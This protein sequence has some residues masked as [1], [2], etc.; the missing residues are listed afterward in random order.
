MKRKVLQDERITAEHQKLNSQ[1]FYIIFA[2]LMVSLVVKVFI[3]HWDMKYWLDVFLI[4]IAA[5][6]YITV[7]A[8]RRGLYLLPGQ[9]GEKP[10]FKKANLWSGAIGAIVWTILMISYD[11]LESGTTD[12]IKNVASA[13]VGGVIFF[14]GM[15]WIQRALV[16][17]STQN[18]DKPLD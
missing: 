1:G 10:N 18:G 6:I 13:W 3:F 12:L 4:M 9:A 7:K 17:R 16:R 15:N 14:F 2:G 8:I 5:C 11:L